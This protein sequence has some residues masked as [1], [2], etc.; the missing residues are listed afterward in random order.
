MASVF[1]HKVLLTDGWADDV[2][3]TISNGCFERIERGTSIAADDR[4][5]DIVVPGLCN[6]HSHAFQRALV[7][8]TEQRSPQGQDNFWSWR[9]QMYAL[10]NRIDA[11]SMQ[12]IAAQVY[13]EMLE[14]GYTSVAEFHYLHDKPAED[15][16]SMFEAI[17][18]AATASGIR[19]NYVPVL[20]ERAGF[21]A[22]G[23]ADNQRRF[24]LGLDEYLEHFARCTA[25]ATERLSVSLGAHSLR[26]VSADSLTALA[27]AAQQTG[28]AMHLHIA[29]QSAEVEQCLAA[30]G[31][32]PVDWLLD[33]VAVDDRWCL[34]HA[35]HIDEHEV[36]RLAQ[37][38]AV[39]CVCPST[40]ANLG[41][42]LFPLRAFL[43]QGGRIAIGSDSHVTVNPFEE[44][45]WLEY[46]QRLATQSRNVAAVGASRVGHELFTRVLEGGAQTGP[47]VPAGIAEGAH[48]DLLVLDGGAPMLAGHR[49]ATLLDALI[50][51]GLRSPI[52]RVMV[53]GEWRVIN[54]YH[55]EHDKVLADFSAAM[56][57]IQ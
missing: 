29:E 40:E 24:A 17:A 33:T 51:S 48:A 20:Y 49:D 2:R 52:D 53:H 6:A 50:F 47:D 57:R 36:T 12:S 28:T 43:E 39:V 42:G 21:D 46:G 27:D 13:V 4:R 35:T 1:A 5:A 44:L 41:D 45:R 8:L 14:S 18:A 54:G 31:N 15:G 16:D 22:A 26:A 25:A 7:G 56:V 34:V 55:V 38:E 9:T 10:A 11:A 19:T 30:T 3:L 32:R 23:Y 37:T